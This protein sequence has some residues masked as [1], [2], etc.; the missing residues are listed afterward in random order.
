MYS[1]G[2]QTVRDNVKNILTRYCNRLYSRVLYCWKKFVEYEDLICF[3]VRG[4]VQ[5]YLKSQVWRKLLQH[6]Y[7]L[8]IIADHA[9]SQEC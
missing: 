6:V 1:I 3:V 5:I 7:T 2:G 8:L 9:D 4:T